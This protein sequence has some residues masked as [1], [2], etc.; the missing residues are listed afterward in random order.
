MSL[1]PRNPVLTAAALFLFACSA[2]TATQVPT[3]DGTVAGGGATTSSTTS[4][5]TDPGDA[6]PAPTSPP[7][8]GTPEAGMPP[9]SGGPDSGATGTGDSGAVDS[10]PGYFIDTGAAHEAAVPPPA[11]L[12]SCNNPA[13]ATDGTECGCQAIDSLGEQI[14]MGCQAGGQCICLTNMQPQDNPFDEN[15]ACNAAPATAQQFLQF[16][17]CN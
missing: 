11:P 13:C 7:Q 9:P 2:T 10:G 14:L 3:G 4:P 12:G 6:G 17:N 8:T 5:T 15:G 16:C 1:R